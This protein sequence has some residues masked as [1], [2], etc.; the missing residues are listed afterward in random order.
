M[1]EIEERL[2]RFPRDGRL[3][4]IGLTPVRREPMIEVRSVSAAV[5]RGLEGDRR[6][7]GHPTKRE[8]TLIQAE[9]LAVIGALIGR[10][11]HPADVRRNLVVSGINLVALKGRRFRV[12]E[13]TLEWTGPCDPCS[14]MEEAL[15][16]GGLNAMRGHGGITARVVEGGALAVGDL[17]RFVADE[18]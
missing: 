15:G 3:E 8:V 7:K 11:V 4:W 14:R 2:A 12:G 18:R 16:P 1:T 13:V 5:G 10:E 9:H 17:V 6:A